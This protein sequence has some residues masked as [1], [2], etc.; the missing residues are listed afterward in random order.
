[1]LAFDLVGMVV[2]YHNTPLRV[3]MYIDEATPNWVIS[4]SFLFAPFSSARPPRK[5]GESIVGGSCCQLVPGLGR[6]FRKA[7]IVEP[8]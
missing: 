4:S 7:V 1:M 8:C 5:A 6:K 3:H 2:P